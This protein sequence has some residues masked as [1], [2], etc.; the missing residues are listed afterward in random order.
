M[1]L[2]I[3]AAFSGPETP[4]CKDEL[5]RLRALGIHVRWILRICPFLVIL[6]MSQKYQFLGFCC[7]KCTTSHVFQGIPIWTDYL[8][9]PDFIL[10][11]TLEN[12]I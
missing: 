11:L 5:Q 9:S 4:G 6:R 3:A 12:R 2:Q 1:A 8:G 10:T 7:S